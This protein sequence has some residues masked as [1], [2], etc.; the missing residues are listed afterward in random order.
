MTATETKLID[1]LTTGLK[2]NRS[3]VVTPQT[4]IFGKGGGPGQEMS[5]GGLGLDSVDILEIAVLLDKHF[6]VMLEEQNEEVH[7]AL[8]SIAT[9]AAY[10]DQHAS[11]ATKP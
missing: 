6:G 5:A 9:L 3:I 4:A 8:T 2:L 10:I 7:Q 1:V 11:P